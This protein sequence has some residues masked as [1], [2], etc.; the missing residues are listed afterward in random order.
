[1]AA[2][3]LG[4]GRALAASPCPPWRRAHWEARGRLKPQYDAVV[5]GAGKGAVPELRGRAALL[6]AWGAGGGIC[7]AGSAITLLCGLGQILASPRLGS[8]VLE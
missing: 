2:S 4:L 3:G 1:M 5:I 6:R 7:G 8:S